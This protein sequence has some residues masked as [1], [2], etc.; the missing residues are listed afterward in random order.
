M[1]EPAKVNQYISSLQSQLMIFIDTSIEGKLLSVESASA[2]YQAVAE[3]I[4]LVNSKK[5][6]SAD[7]LRKFARVVRNHADKAVSV[8]RLQNITARMIGYV[9]WHALVHSCDTT[10]R[11]INLSFGR[12]LNMPH[13]FGKQRSGYAQASNPIDKEKQ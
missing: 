8:D 3:L 11:A 1:T 4:A 13:I 2:I 12:M 9:D 5:T 10:G 6:I 7:T